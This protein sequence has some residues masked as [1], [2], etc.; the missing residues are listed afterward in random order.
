MGG[1]GDDADDDDDQTGQVRADSHKCFKLALG[2]RASVGYTV[3]R[4]PG[5]RFPV[6]DAGIFFFQCFR[7]NNG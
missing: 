7:A 5:N 3:K 1:G 2:I 6:A 4:F